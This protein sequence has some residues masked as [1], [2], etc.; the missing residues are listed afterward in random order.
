MREVMPSRRRLHLRHAISSAIRP[1]SFE[2]NKARMRM[3]RARRFRS[4]LPAHIAERTAASAVA[5]V[6]ELDVD[7]IGSVNQD[8]YRSALAL[9][10]AP[11]DAVLGKALDNLVRIES[12]N[13]ESDVGPESCRTASLNQ[14]DELWTGSNAQDGNRRSHISFS[15]RACVRLLESLQPHVGQ[16]QIP[17]ERGLDIRHDQPDM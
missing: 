17:F 1:A 3:R 2:P 6:L 9:P 14:C 8:L 4:N 16:L 5:D 11:P 10:D 7:P 12:L 15:S 13:A